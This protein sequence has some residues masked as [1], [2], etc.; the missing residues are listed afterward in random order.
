MGDYY[1]FSKSDRLDASRWNLEVG[2]QK[3]IYW[4]KISALGF[5]EDLEKYLLINSNPESVPEALEACKTV[6]KAY[7]SSISRRLINLVK[8]VFSKIF[9]VTVELD[10]M[11]K[12]QKRINQCSYPYP[13][14]NAIKGNNIKLV[15]ELIGNYKYNQDLMNQKDEKGLSTFLAAIEAENLEA[16]CLLNFLRNQL[17]IS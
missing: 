13:L 7:E 1:Y 15:R 5:L 9:S 14:H 4:N 17:F 3:P 10:E 11:K 8:R 12:I 6:V 2:D 16:L